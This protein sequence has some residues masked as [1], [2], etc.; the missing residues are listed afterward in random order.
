MVTA[1]IPT[2]SIT[3][4]LKEKTWAP[5]VIDPS[6]SVG[7]AVYVPAC[8]LA[9]VAYGAD[10][11]C[12]RSRTSAR[13][14]VLATTRKSRLSHQTSSLETIAQAKQLWTLRRGNAN[15]G[16][17]SLIPHFLTHAEA[18]TQSG[19]DRNLFCKEPARR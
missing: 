17:G 3:P 11:L 13:A 6:H 14:T 5:V 18:E 1:T 7:K 19:G 16:P 10:G 9:A 4:L 8:A 2:K 15:V 12:I